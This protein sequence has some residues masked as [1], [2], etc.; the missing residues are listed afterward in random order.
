MWQYQVSTKICEKNEKVPDHVSVA[1]ARKN[2]DCLRPQAAGASRKRVQGNNNP[3]KWKGKEEEVPGRRDGLWS[4]TF[5]PQQ[6]Q[7]AMTHPIGP[8]NG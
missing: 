1:K 5:V 2:P 6:G 4:G 7:Q 3:R 8:G